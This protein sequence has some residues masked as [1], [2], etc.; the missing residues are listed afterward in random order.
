MKQGDTPRTNG[1]DERQ[2]YRIGDHRVSG[3]GE[4]R[5]EAL[6][7]NRSVTR[8]GARVAPLRCPILHGGRRR[9]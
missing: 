2:V 7:L 3:K 5:A 4:G 6:P 1:H 9:P 8:Y